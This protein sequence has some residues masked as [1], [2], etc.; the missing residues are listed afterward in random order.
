MDAFSQFVPACS[1]TGTHHT[2]HSI[3]RFSGV[4][5]RDRTFLPGSD[6]RSSQGHGYGLRL[7]NPFFH[8][9]FPS[10]FQKEKRGWVAERAITESRGSDDGMEK[11]AYPSE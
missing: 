4:V 10:L 8:L 1:A 2:E 7:L 5:K 3:S 9:E 11:A 6:P